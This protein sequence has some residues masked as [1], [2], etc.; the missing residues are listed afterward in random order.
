LI[1]INQRSDNRQKPFFLLLLTK[2]PRGGSAINTNAPI[3]RTN[4]RTTNKQTNLEALGPFI[5]FACVKKVWQ[6]K[7]T[8][9]CG[10]CHDSGSDKQQR[11]QHKDE[12]DKR[13]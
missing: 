13:V 7:C 1:S 3:V 5:F 4:V 8:S 11:Q 2:A 9:C 6:M 12:K 10:K